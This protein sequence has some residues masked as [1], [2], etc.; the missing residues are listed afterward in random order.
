MLPPFYSCPPL[1]RFWSIYNVLLTANTISVKALL[2]MSFHMDHPNFF[3]FAVGTFAD[4]SG[5]L[6][7]S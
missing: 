1:H 4:A 5:M 7:K 2:C 6:A 3:P